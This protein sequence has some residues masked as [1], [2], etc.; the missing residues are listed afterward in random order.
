MVGVNREGG[1]GT[2]GD[3]ST[4][5]GAGW[6]GVDIEGKA[7]AV[8]GNTGVEML[9]GEVSTGI[10]ILCFEICCCRCCCCCCCCC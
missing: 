8:V 7:V 6:G 5:D 9:G 2:Y 10:D 1:E 3:V 4:G